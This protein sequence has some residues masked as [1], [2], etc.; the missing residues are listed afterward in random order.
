MIKKCIIRFINGFCYSIAITVV[1][2]LIATCFIGDIP[3]LPE[4]IDRFNNQ[5]I[6]YAVQ[7]LFIGI[8]S[9]VTSAGTIVFEAKKIG[10]LVQSVIF[11]CIMLS[12]WIPVS[13]LCWGFHKYKLSM[14]VTTISIVFSYIICW[15]IQYMLSKRDIDAI[16][17][18]LLEK[19]EGE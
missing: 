19:K 2:H 11:L 16:N 17:A 7:L 12:A 5:I 6:A 9:G 1:F 3:M 13:C 18:K 14:I 15:T 8:M 10:L 4:F